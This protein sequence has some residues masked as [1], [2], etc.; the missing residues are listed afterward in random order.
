[1]LLLK[2]LNAESL[3][4]FDMCFY[5]EIILFKGEIQFVCSCET[6]L[7]R[8]KHTDSYQVCIKGVQM[9]SHSATLTVSCS[10]FV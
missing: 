5:F 3:I 2:S 1:M 4:V 7:K 6:S 10:I 9:I 8:E